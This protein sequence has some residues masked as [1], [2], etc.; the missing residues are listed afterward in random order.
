MIINGKHCVNVSVWKSKTF[1]F[2]EIPM[3]RSYLFCSPAHSWC[4]TSTL[5]MVAINTEEYRSYK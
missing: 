3:K 5:H 2:A 4:L 1:V